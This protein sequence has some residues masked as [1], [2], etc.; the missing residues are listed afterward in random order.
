MSK[1]VLDVKQKLPHG[2]KWCKFQDVTDVVRGGSP[3]PKGDPRYFGGTIPWIMIRDISKEKGKFLTKTRDTVTED[4]AKKSRLLKKGSLILSNSGTVC[5]P[6]ILKVEGC[7]HDGF[8]TFPDIPKNMN[9]DYAYYW[10]EKI[11]TKIRQENQQGVTQVN[12]NIQIVKIIDV[13]LPPL[14]EQKRIVSKIEELFSKMNSIKQ[15][16][17]QTKLQLEQYRQSLLSNLLQQLSLKYPSEKLVNLCI[18]ISDGTHF[19]PKYVHDGIPFISV[20]D[21]RNEKIY[22]DNCKHVSKETHD[23]L[24]KRCHP[25]FGDLLITKSGTIGRMAIVNTK[26]PFSLF[27]SVALIKPLKNIN[28]K[29]LKY[30]LEN[31]LNHIDVSQEIKGTAIKNFHLEDIRN[32]IIPIPPDSKQQEIVSTIEQNFLL[33]DNSEKIINSILLQ[34]E[35]LY[36]SVLKQ[37]FEGKLVPQDP[38]D[39]PAEILLQKIKQDK[40]Q[41]IQNQKT[42]RSTKNVK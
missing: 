24:I 32:V 27:V 40:E 16:V 39:E 42:S 17:E 34:L 25:E 3:R 28:R 22:F 7:I 14:N 31:F 37:A 21:I 4:G 19:T 23:N 2:W 11:R 18:K 10:F 35:S 33:V 12:L 26:I 6:K 9:I 38:N 20:K 1:L 41:L 8:L 29:Y 13:P 36:F 30:I 15:L 5:V